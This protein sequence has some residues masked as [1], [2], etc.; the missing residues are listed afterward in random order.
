M[1]GIAG[2]IGQHLQI[3]SMVRAL[4]HRGPDGLGWDAI[5]DGVSFGH[6]RLAIIDPSPAGRQPMA[7]G[8]WRITYNGEIYNFRELRAH[9]EAKG[10]RFTTQTDTEVLLRMWAVYG[11]DCL[12]ALDGQFA[13]AVYNTDSRELTL[14]RD[15]AGEKPLYWRAGDGFAFASELRP[16]VRPGDEVDPDSLALYALYRYVPAPR[17]ILLG[18]QKLPPAHILVYRPDGTHTLRRW[19]SWEVEPHHDV[20]VAGFRRAVDQVEA[21]L[22]ES[23]RRRLVADVPLGMFL[24]GGIDS[25]LTAA[26]AARLGHTPKTFSIGFE[27]AASEHLEA[28]AIARHLGT[29]HHEHI[30]TPADFEAVGRSI[31]AKLDEP[32]G[33]RSCIPAYLLSWFARDHVKVALS[34]D[35]GDE[36]FGG[37]QRYF[38]PCASPADYYQNLLPVYGDA[39][40]GEMEA[41]DPLWRTLDPLHAR[42]AL[43]FNRYLPGCVLSKMDRM[44]M[45]HGLEVRTP[46]LMPELMDL[47]RTLPAAYLVNGNMGKLVLR[48]I[49]S[50]YLPRDVALAPKRGFG[51]PKGVFSQNSK[52]IAEMIEDAKPHCERAGFPEPPANM[53]AVWC[54]IVLGQ[55]LGSL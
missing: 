5:D 34:G 32:N 29:E 51:M 25:S 46:F 2:A 33:D 55:W 24:S 37:Y 43:D 16:Q 18:V 47:A 53:N 48:E 40:P 31:G 41:A 28:R 26:F 9:L 52:V 35:G 10:E 49:A 30:V 19:W 20:S 12:P 45:Q 38:G 4:E 3:E 1:C 50:R 17:T 14:V 23:V 44:S 15:R 11:A 13:F 7:F 39:H 42:R 6:S 54:Y 21:M 36:L 22:Q 27:G 8:P